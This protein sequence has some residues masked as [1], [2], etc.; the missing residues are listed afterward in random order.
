MQ[1]TL[2]TSV[3]GGG[4]GRMLSLESAGRGLVLIT[5]L[6]GLTHRKLPHSLESQPSPLASGD[7]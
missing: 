3:L 4:K 5:S 2:I 7:T 6:S 1:T